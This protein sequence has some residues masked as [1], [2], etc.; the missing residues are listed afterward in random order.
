[1]TGYW[2]VNLCDGWRV[3]YNGGEGPRFA[4]VA[5]GRSA[6]YTLVVSDAGT[7]V[8]FVAISPD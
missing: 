6:L 3:G 2:A 5:R 7:G 8:K 1:M 4:P